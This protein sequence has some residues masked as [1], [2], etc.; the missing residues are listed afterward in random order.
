[1]AFLFTKFYKMNHDNTKNL[2]YQ[3]Q[4]KR[5][6]EELIYMH[7]V[8]NRVLTSVENY[9]ETKSKELFH[10][11]DS[12]FQTQGMLQDYINT[13]FINES[14]PESLNPFLLWEFSAV[15]FMQGYITYM[16]TKFQ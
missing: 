8:E 15:K 1:M 3:E 9:L 11:I 7:S 12:R 16:R 5:V 2:H 14:N 10:E 13:D 6:M 4:Y